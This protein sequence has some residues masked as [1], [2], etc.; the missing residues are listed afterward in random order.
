MWRE[1]GVC[2]DFFER[3][4]HGFLAEGTSYFLEGEELLVRVVL[5]EVDV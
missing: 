2:L 3:Q 5:H 4:A 1:E